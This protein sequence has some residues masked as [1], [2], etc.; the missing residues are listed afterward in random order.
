MTLRVTVIGTIDNISA[1]DWDACA[2]PYGNP[3]L[4]HRFLLALEQSGSAV[5]EAGWTPL[6]IIAKNGDDIKGVMP[7][8]VKTHSQGEYI[9]DHGWAEAYH[10][11]GGRYYPKLVSAV[12]FTPATGPRV[13][14]DDSD[15]Q[16]VLISGACQLAEQNGFSSLHVNFIPKDQ[17]DQLG[18]MGL[19]QRTHEQFHWE[20]DS[21]ENFDDFLAALQSRKR[22]QI[23][24]ER[25]QAA[26]NVKIY[27]FSG[28]D[29]L[30]EHWDA[31][32]QFYQDTG[33]RKYGTP[34]LS[35]AFFDI[36]QDTL[37]SDVVLLLAERDGHWVAGA[38]N[39]IGSDTL[40]GRY[41][42]CIEDHPMLHFELCYY[43]AIDIA[44]RLGLK[45]VE[46]GAQGS[47][48]LARGYLPMTTY[49]A[50]WIMDEG[51]RGPVANFLD[52]E[53]DAVAGDIEHMQGY[54][55][56]KRGE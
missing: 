21:Y 22:K 32:W 44:I 47:H 20:N 53:R 43:R 19:L 18:N 8:Y 3:F 10:R 41:W 26:E 16:N 39:F 1:D 36:A 6:H 34:Y 52:H 38:L 23:R 40:Y 48:K 2:G 15:V 42:G 30:P 46:A 49:S 11:A 33:A 14:S 51:L 37:R 54:T 45:R 13:L 7:L 5:P 9:F 28:D 55:P 24:K 12:P 4:Y 35:R 25:A 27:E 29:I 56:F 50:H 31:F 17:Y